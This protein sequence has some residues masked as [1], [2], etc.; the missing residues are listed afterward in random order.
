MKF[1]AFLETND[2]YKHLVGD[3]KALKD[4]KVF[5]MSDDSTQQQ[6]AIDFSQ[7]KDGTVALLE[8]FTKLQKA[9]NKGD[10]KRNKK[11]DDLIRQKEGR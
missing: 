7:T 10:S 5:Y 1:N 3:P 9:R 8:A 11:I 2:K 6:A 4:P